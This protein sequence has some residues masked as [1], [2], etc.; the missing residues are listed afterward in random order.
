MCYFPY[1]HHKQNG[2]LMKYAL[3]VILLYVVALMSCMDDDAVVNSSTGSDNAPTIATNWTP[4][5]VSQIGNAMSASVAAG[6]GGGLDEYFRNSGVVVK[7]GFYYVVNGVHPVKRDNFTSYYP[8]SLVKASISS[9]TVEMRC[10]YYGSSS[11]TP[12][13][14]GGAA[15]NHEVD[16]EALTFGPDGGSTY[17]YVGDEYNYIYQIRLSDC[18][19]TK[20]W[21]LADIGVTASVDKG[22]EALA[23]SPETG[24][25]YAG[26]QDNI[27][28][29]EIELAELDN[30]ANPSRCGLALINTF[31]TEYSPSGLF[32]YPEQSVLY[33][34]AGTTT[35]GDQ[36][37]DAYTTAGFRKCAITIPKAMGIS[38]GDGFFIDGT[39][40]Y[41]A[42]SQGPMW[43]V[44]GS[45]GYN[46]YETKW[47]DPCNLGGPTY[48]ESAEVVAE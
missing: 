23:Y 48:E 40:A 33:V 14:L 6:D 11:E 47:T 38:R 41:I 24:Y 45:M 18:G 31:P 8:K 20:Q 28:I 26:I 27:E 17:V 25:F 9:D 15:I 12:S 42:D 37:L 21:N 29:H 39:S 10:S 44:E 16:M 19:I 2:A 22:V 30:C 3:L 7:D 46:L 5:I 43:T 32:F 13:L 34:F 1:A 4:Q 36:Y 35:N